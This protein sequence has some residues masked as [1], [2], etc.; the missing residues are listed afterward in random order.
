MD[1]RYN[2]FRSVSLIKLVERRVL[3]DRISCHHTARLRE[4]V[5]RIRQVG[6]GLAWLLPKQMRKTKHKQAGH[7]K[8]FSTFS[9]LSVL[10]FKS[11]GFSARAARFSLPQSTP[12]ASSQT[13]LKSPSPLKGLS[14]HSIT[15]CP[16]G[17][18]CSETECRTRGG[19]HIH[20]VQSWCDWVESDAEL[21]N[22]GLCYVTNELTGR[23]AAV[24]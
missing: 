18:S 19:S 17:R 13:S 1:T 2:F 23:P 10:A 7:R 14:V 15:R 4:P 3:I 16:R 12:R 24:S 20:S 9:T 11:S 21:K 22:L 6:V 5:W 8:T